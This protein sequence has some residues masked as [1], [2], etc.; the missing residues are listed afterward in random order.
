MIRVPHLPRWLPDGG[1]P[2]SGSS[3]SLVEN[4]LAKVIRPRHVPR[5]DDQRLRTRCSSQLDLKSTM[6]RTEDPTSASQ[7]MHLNKC[8]DLEKI[9]HRGKKLRSSII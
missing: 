5:G 4:E 2:L 6:C 9:K 7:P 1:G 8:T 3:E